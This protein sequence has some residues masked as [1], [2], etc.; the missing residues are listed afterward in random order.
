M[1]NQT[2]GLI[3]LVGPFVVL[4]LAIIVGVVCALALSPS[5][6]AAPLPDG[7]GVGFIFIVGVLGLTCMMSFLVGVPLS[8][9]WFRQS[10][11]VATKNLSGDNN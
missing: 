3:A 7:M 8:I 2:K 1:R 11:N 10:D 5:A 4:A 9:Y 6:D